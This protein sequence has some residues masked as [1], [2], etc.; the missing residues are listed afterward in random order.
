MN[1][2]TQQMRYFMELATCLNFTRAAANLYVAQPTLSQ[3]IAEL[4]T[5]LGVTLF[6]RNSRSVTL[7][8]A[9]MILYT[10][11]PDIL[12]RFQNIQQHMLVTAAGFSGA[13]NIGFQ[14]IFM[15]TIPLILRSFRKS[16]PEIVVTPV[17]GT[18]N[19]LNKGL[20]N[21]TVDIAFSVTQDFVTEEFSSFNRKL[22]MRENLCFVLSSEL[23]V[24]EAPAPEES[25]PLIIFD[26][27]SASGY[28]THVN[29]CLKKLGIHVPKVIFTDSLGNL[30]TYLESGIGFSVLPQKY[31]MFF[32]EETRFVPVPDE[33][34]DCGTLWDPNSPN[35]ALPLFLDFLDQFLNPSP[36]EDI[37]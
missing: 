3:Q 31:R 10:A 36:E 30:R 19:E 12:E 4:E 8:P 24:P 21:A 14:D 16:F 11:F 33:F 9:G 26:E 35:P 1:I 15:D 27:S 29:I 7:T 28:H 23:P 2:N 34:L 20:K 18:V 37:S 5:Q 32:S 13:L 25:C 6:V 22:I 17:C